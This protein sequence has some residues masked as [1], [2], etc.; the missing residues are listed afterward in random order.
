MGRK[1][2]LSRIRFPRV[3]PY[4]TFIITTLIVYLILSTVV[5]SK[6][7]KFQVGEIAKFD[8]KAPRDVEDKV[9]TQKSIEEELKH[10]QETYTYDANIRKGA[11]DNINKLFELVKKINSENPPYNP[12][13]EDDNE[14]IKSEQDKING[15]KLKKLKE[16]GVIKNLSTENY[17]LLL[18]LNDTGLNSLNEEIVNCM[19]NL[20]DTTPIYENKPQDIVSAQGYIT[21]FFNNTSYA[22]N[23]KDLAMA[24]GYSQTKATYFVDHEKTEEARQN[25]TKNVTPVIY[26]KDQTIIAEGQPITESQIELLNDLGLLDND[27][28]TGIYMNLVLLLVVAGVLGLQWRYIKEKRRDIYED[29]S[30]VILINLLTVLTVVLARISIV[31]SPYVI[32]FACI[33][34][35]LSVLID[36][37]TSV[38]IG[39]LNVIFISFIVKFSVDLTLIAM[40]NAVIVPMVLKRVQQRNDIL[41]S[42]LLI[43]AINVVFT[44]AMGYFLSTNLTSIINKAMLTGV[45]AIVSGILAIGI[46]PV[47]ENIFDVLTNI[48]LLEL[49]NPNHPLMRRLLLEAPGTYHHCVLVANLAEMAAE[50]VGANPIFARVASYYHDVGKLER[51]YYFKENQIGIANPHDDMS[52]AMSSAII[53]SHVEDGVKLAEKYNLPEGI[54]DVVREHHGDSLAKYFYITMRNKSD[55]PDEVN[56]ADYRYGGPPPRSKESTIIMLADG[57]EA[58]V[59][60]INKPN[61]KKIEEMVNNIIKSRIDENQFVNSDLTFKDLEKIRESFLKVLSGIYHERIEYPK[62]K[63]NLTN[64]NNDKN[65]KEDKEV[66]STKE[67]QFK[68]KETET[69]IQT[70][71]VEKEKQI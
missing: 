25:I 31:I 4:I 60:S 50:S 45:S 67:E 61:K 3:K 46:L 10:V 6:K 21:A 52:P 49:A 66:V 32:P 14:K 22:K 43:G 28:S 36:S 1:K 37:K 38:T 7:Y 30:K 24:I 18:S 69:V 54:T 5:V 39:I 58:S 55:N 20:Y 68:L 65:L 23:V 63:I 41:Y 29:N 9:A 57:V 15:I 13:S 8:I 19:N 34:I 12:S 62:D 2:R 70:K 64:E 47:L 17:G 56:E 26:K 11:L 40:V 27:K 33:S 16:E 35:L 51:P 59:R 48:K 44:G 71:E 42:S 53:L